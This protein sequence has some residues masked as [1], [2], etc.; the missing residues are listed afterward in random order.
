MYPKSSYHDYICGTKFRDMANY[1]LREGSTDLVHYPER[2]VGKLP[3][4]YSSTHDFKYLMQAV[5]KMDKDVVV[6]THNSDGEVRDSRNGPLR[7]FDADASLLH[8]NVHAWFAQNVTVD[9]EGTEIV[10]IPIG[11]ENRY[12]FD[13]DKAQMLFAKKADGGRSDLPT[14][15]LNCNV[16]NNKAERQQVYDLCQNLLYVNVEYGYN[17]LDYDH[18]LTMTRRHCAT[19]SPRGNGLDCH[20]TWEALYLERI[21][22][23]RAERGLMS[24]NLPIVFLKDW[25]ELKDYDK[26]M[27]M[28]SDCIT[29][30]YDYAL[31][32]EY[33]RKRILNA[34]T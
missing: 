31:S 28:M 30:S 6:I 13:Y 7:E 8:P 23:M 2:E 12:C 24:W 11:L 18:F 10:P 14:F 27:S 21:P 16:N 4:V 9:Y 3:V 15:Y 20:R 19:I 17:G 5:D 26:I 25:E 33:W 34:N 29:E 1:V 32:F 22:I